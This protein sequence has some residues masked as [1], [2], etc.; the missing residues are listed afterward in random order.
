M[1]KALLIAEKP[2]LMRAVKAV[3]DKY[4]HVDQIDFESF[5][6]HT[7]RLCHPEEYREDWSKWTL[8][9]LPM[10]PE[11]F[12]YVP[13]ADKVEMFNRIKNKIEKGHYD[14]LINCCDPDREGDG[15]FFTFYQSINC[16]LPVKRMWHLDLTDKE[17]K[18][19]LDNPRDNFNDPLLK[20][21]KDASMLRAIFDWLVGMNFSRAV[22]I[23]GKTKVP[24]G[25]VMTPTLK[26]VVDRE[27]E[28]RNFKPVDF[29]E[30]EA[31]FTSYK[32]LYFDHNNENN[33][34]F[35]DESKALDFIKTL[36]GDG[37][38]EDFQTERQTN[39]APKLHSLADLQNEANRTYG[40]TLDKTLAIIQSL[41]E[42][43]ILSY[44][45][46]DCPYLSEEIA[47]GLKVNIAAIKNLDCVKAQAALID[48]AA[49]RAMVSNKRYVND[50]KVTAHYAIIPTGSTFNFDTL[51]VEEQNI[52]T[53]VAKRLVAIFMNPVLTD[54]TTIITNL[55]DHKFKTTGT[56]LIDKGYSVLYGKT[57][58]DVE[59]PKVKK[60]DH[61]PFKEAKLLKKA[62][63]PPPR[64]DDASLNTAMENA[65]KFVE[66]EELKEVLKKT[67]GIG[68]PATRAGIIS[69]LISLKMIQRQGSGKKKTFMA[70][71]YGISII[72]SLNNYSIVSPELTGI[73]EGK[74]KDVGTG[75][76]PKEKFKEEMINY[77]QAQTLEFI[78]NKDIR[79]S[80][81]GGK[82]E[83]GRCPLC[84]GPVIVGNNFYL[85][86]HFGKEDNKCKF[87][88]A[89]EIL[90]AKITKAEAIKLL[91]LKPTKKLKLKKKDNS[92]FEASL[93]YD[94][95][96]KQICFAGSS[97]KTNGKSGEVKV[98]GKCPIC[99]EDILDRGKF[100]SCKDYKTCSFSI[101]YEI[102]GAKLTATDVK[103]L[104]K[105][106]VVGPKTFNWK[107]GK[108]GEAKLKYN[109]K[110]KK[111]EFVFK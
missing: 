61:Y 43:K 78:N 21:I 4:G 51:P 2:D 81:T 96:K 6:G 24:L 11:P 14:Y 36:K 74:L 101:S 12:K 98:L 17:L 65:G 60:G 56:V 76:M 93:I 13:S 27:L 87:L 16:K 106:D 47:K 99:G 71:D 73:W 91:S 23:I 44:P 102:M 103:K 95:D 32:G 37:I 1:K 28:L 88:I 59:L 35:F 5:A 83:I 97:N 55:N 86:G 30:I 72:Q 100:C 110:T 3:Y 45:R 26:I 31:D 10:I 92:T 52:V 41:Y 48:D 80:T 40:Y 104:I 46:T 50:K 54:K 111:L 82:E 62:T 94:V 34:R 39:Y 29:W 57:F 77:I 108:S 33:T 18:K 70:T 42:K 68:T 9:T 64:Y 69:K 85:C 79:I 75:A 19:N 8:D 15:I 84:G 107:G 63:T 20:Y 25:R 7:M 58:T 22:S 67:E 66:D 38:V 105:G 49:I 53:L 90:G 109:S 89:K